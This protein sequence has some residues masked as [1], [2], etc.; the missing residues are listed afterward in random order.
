LAKRFAAFD[1]ADNAFLFIHE[2]LYCGCNPVW[3]YLNGCVRRITS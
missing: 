2:L 1:V 3:F